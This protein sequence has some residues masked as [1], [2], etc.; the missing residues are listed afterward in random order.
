M[1]VVFPDTIYLSYCVWCYLCLWVGRS[2]E[3]QEESSNRHR[4][5][6]QCDDGPPAASLGEVCLCLLTLPLACFVWHPPF[7]H[8]R[9]FIEFCMWLYLSINWFFSNQIDRELCTDGYLD[10]AVCGAS[11]DDHESDA[12]QQTPSLRLLHSGDECTYDS[13]MCALD[14]VY[15]STNCCLA[16]ACRMTLFA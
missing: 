8:R 5:S 7:Q 2:E 14:D 13:Y 3:I 16:G 4:F 6:L 9:N 11:I 12:H 15:K 10:F 1:Y